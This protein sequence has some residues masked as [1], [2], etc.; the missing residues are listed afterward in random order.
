[1]L[2]IEGAYGE[3]GGWATSWLPSGGGTNDTTPK[4]QGHAN[5]DSIVT[6]QYGKSDWSFSSTVTSSVSGF[7]SFETPVLAHGIWNFRVQ[8]TDKSGKTTDWSNV[9]TLDIGR[10]ST[11]VKS[12][13]NDAEWDGTGIYGV[14][15]DDDAPAAINTLYVMGSYQLLDLT[16]LHND[17]SSLNTID[18]TGK[19]DNQLTMHAEDILA[20]GQHSLF[21]DDKKKQIQVKGNEGDSV[22][23]ARQLE[24]FEAS[25]WVV[26][27]GTITSSGVEYHVWHNQNSEVEILIQAGLKTDLM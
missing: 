23:L 17:I 3:E 11:S 4:L 20:L 10:T 5:A 18:L 8:S 22:I 19:G 16:E 13:A 6:I 27:K 7:W 9:F 25:E 1:V 24:N 26:A 21:I 12:F 14:D 2:E 15:L